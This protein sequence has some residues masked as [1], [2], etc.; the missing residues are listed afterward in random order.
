MFSPLSVLL[1]IV[2][3]VGLLFGLAQWGEQRTRRGRPINSGTI[4][5]LSLCVYFTTWTFYGSVGFATRSGLLYLGIYAGALLSLFFWQYTIRRMIAVK[6]TFH[7]TS[8]ADLIS[9]RYR[10]SQRIA[11]MVTL[12]ALLGLLPY[13]SLQLEAV[14]RSL[15]LITHEGAGQIHWSSS[16]LLI[17]LLMTVFTILFGVRRLDPTE[18]HQGMILALVAECLVKLLVFLTIGLYISYY[19][20]DGPADIYQQIKQHDLDHLLSSGGDDSGI[21]WLTLIIL[22]FVGVQLL[23]RQFHVGV[24]ENVSPT[25][26]GRALWMFPLYTVLITLFVIPIAA[27]GLILGLPAQSADFFMLLVPQALDQP[28]MALLSFL[29]GF[30]AASGM[31]I[32]TTMTL[33]TM[34]SNHLL[35]PVCEKF[36]QLAWMRT[37]LLQVRWVL[38]AIILFGSLLLARLL[39]DT[40]MLVAVGMISFVAALQFA[41]A[42]FLGLFWSRGNSMGALLGLMAG[43]IA[44]GWTLIIPAWVEEGWLPLS[45]LSMGPFGIDWLR[46]QA[47]FGMDLPSIPH[48]VLFSLAL[49]TLF[50][51]LGSWLYTPQKQERTLTTEFLYTTRA[52]R[53]QEKARPTGLNAYVELAPK[54]VEAEQLL[55]RYLGEEKAQQIVNRIADDLQV[56]DKSHISVV[57]LMEF[58]RMLEQM[59]AG[60]IGAASAHT[61]IEENIRYTDRE[62]SDL[63]SLYSHIVNEL[64]GSYRFHPD[65]ADEPESRGLDMLEELQ[66]QLEHLQLKTDQQAR[67]REQLEAKLERQYQEIFD[68]RVEAQRLRQENETLRQQVA[69][70]SSE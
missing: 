3:Y 48:A 58:H 26:L 56:Y 39:T 25:H 57:E 35:L 7:I 66:D 16:G 40:Y 5:A 8:I 33:A 47:L 9:T 29:G 36:Q 62:R 67:E 13:I 70:R 64:Q 60:A 10:R 54:L 18:R 1:V 55:R 38:V 43:F 30:A 22:S 12:I 27:A 24:V 14:I 19:Y 53:T 41:P 28:Y 50:Y 59:L 63:T 23:P 2:I 31:V 6:E 32:I 45:L 46:P 20:F 11:A 4:Y 42:T 37:W 68:Y 65:K 61:A 52:L 69:G 15:R 51:L 17:T 44:W 49:N 21:Q 34:V